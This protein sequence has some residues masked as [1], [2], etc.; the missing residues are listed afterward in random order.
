MEL[1]VVPNKVHNYPADGQ[2]RQLCDFRTETSPCTGTTRLKWTVTRLSLFLNVLDLKR[3]RHVR[4]GSFALNEL[5]RNEPS[6][7][8]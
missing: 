1:T 8:P 2:S 6:R 4:Q 5:E 3:T 7:Y